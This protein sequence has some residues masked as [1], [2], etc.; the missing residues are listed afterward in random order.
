VIES[1]GLAAAQFALEYAGGRWL[2]WCK[3]QRL[4]SAYRESAEE[5]IELCVQKGYP[6]RSPVWESVTSL[7]RSEE[8]ARQVAH[9]YIQ[10]QIRPNELQDMAKND[11]IVGHF[12]KEFIVRLNNRRAVL[13]PLDLANLADTIIEGVAL[14]L[15]EAKREAPQPIN[16]TTYWVGRPASLG[17]NFFGREAELD[18]LTT[19]FENCRVVVIS[20]GAA[21]G[22]SRL[23]AEYTHRSQQDGFW[24]TVGADLPQTL[25]GLAPSLG[26]SVE[27]GDE[28]IVNEVLRRLNELTQ[29]RG[30]SA[31][32][33]PLVWVV[34]NLA[35]LDL[36]NE[37]SQVVG[38]VNLLVTTRSAR[39]EY[40]PRTA[41]FI[42]LKAL[43]PDPAIELL[44]S[45]RRRDSSWDQSDP[46]LRGLAEEVG[47]LPLALE[48]LAVRLGV[49]QQ[50]PI[51]ILDQLRNAD[52]PIKELEVFQE[53]A[54]AT[55][56]R[57]E[58]V[59]ATIVGVLAE[60]SPEGREQISSLEYTADQPIPDSLLGAL[61]DL[62]LESLNQLIE[63]CSGRSIFAEVNGQVVVHALTI[64]AI[65]ATNQAEDPGTALYRATSHFYWISARADIGAL[66]LEIA[67]YQ[68]LLE[69]TRIVLGSESIEVLNFANNLASGYF[70][71]GRYQEGVQ[72]H[73]ET[74]ATMERALGREHPHTLG[75]RNNLAVGYR[76]L[77]RYQEAA[78][79]DEETLRIQ[80]RVLGPEH[81]DTIQS[82]QGL[83][84]GYRSLGRYQ[85]AVRLFEETLAIRERV[86]GREHPDTLHN[87]Q[88]LALGYWALGRYQEAV[89]LDE[90]TVAIRERVLG[91]EHPDT[92]HSRHNLAS[93]YRSLGRYQEAV[94]LFEETLAIMERVLKPEH[95]NTLQ[96]RQGLALSYWALGRYQEAVQL[97]EETL[98]MRR[99]VLGLEHPDTLDSRH[100][101]ALGYRAV[102][103]NKE[104]DELESKVE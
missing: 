82:R 33:P 104:A 87:C 20:G 38:T 66:R 73:E 98:R 94:Q 36:V 88:G 78:E 80:E 51:Q 47:C 42:E 93:G 30:A 15:D 100:N 95:P 101:L 31:A 54:G 74:L 99:L 13:L 57:A 29:G 96:S 83:A 27:G 62:E 24:T 28:D 97:D 25:I 4:A 71:L 12:I 8:K 56:P 39:Q 21:T 41:A 46:A 69:R 26:V 68:R 35:E 55:I 48:M 32:M 16:R 22:K 63:E 61:T 44:S 102:G 5:T 67:H 37:L 52:T 9:W 90:E 45:R 14:L 77:R 3:R 58:G 75:S 19:V 40:L 49:W 60:L 86:L 34:D 89:Q 53:T 76:Q 70:N 43:K 64:A 92:L 85:E 84:L 2:D 18:A 59:H 103:R 65:E 17:E 11:P 23:A 10:R 50:T 1:I 6:T 7:L 79:L 91:R 72:L 81:P